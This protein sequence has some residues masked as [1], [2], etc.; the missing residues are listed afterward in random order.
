MV[1]FSNSVTLRTWRNEED[2]DLPPR[3]VGLGGEERVAI[4]LR[5]CRGGNGQG[6]IRMKEGKRW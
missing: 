4:V 2:L 6:N 3:L 1:T 5:A